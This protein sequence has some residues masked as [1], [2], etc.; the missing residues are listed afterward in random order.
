MKNLDLQKYQFI[1]F[2]D[3]LSGSERYSVEVWDQEK[4][5]I[6][7]VTN[8]IYAQYLDLGLENDE[9]IS[10]INI[11]T[12][13]GE[14]LDNGNQFYSKLLSYGT[15]HY[16]LFILS[17]I[18]L[19]CKT[20]YFTIKTNKRT[21][22]SN[23]FNL[24]ND[25]YNISRTTLLTYYHSENFYN[26]KYADSGFLPQQIRLPFYYSHKYDEVEAEKY[27]DSYRLE[28]TYRSGKIKRTFFESWNVMLNDY[29]YDALS[30]ALDSDFIYFDETYFNVK[31]FERE[32][33]QENK[34][35]TI[36]KIDGQ[37]VAK[38]KFDDSVFSNIIV[39]KTSDH[40]YDFDY[41][42]DS[43][44]GALNYFQ[45]ANTFNN[46]EDFFGP[47]YNCNLFM[48]IEKVPDN[49]Y[50]M[51]Q[52]KDIVVTVGMKISYCDKDDLVYM[53]K[54]KNNE[55]STS[56]NYL[57][58]FK[59]KIINSL[60]FEGFTVM[61]STL[62]MYDLDSISN[63]IDPI[64]TGIAFMSSSSVKY[65]W[66]INSIAN[67]EQVLFMY[68]LDGIHF[69]QLLIVNTGS[70]TT[71]E[72]IIDLPAFVID[73]QTVYFKI[74]TNS[75]FCGQ[76]SSLI[77]DETYV[78]TPGGIL[79]Q[80]L[81]INYNPTTGYTDYT[82][83]VSGG[84]FQGYVKKTAVSSFNSMNRQLNS[85]QFGNTNIPSTNY[86]STVPTT[87]FE[88]IYNESIH[89]SCQYAPFSTDPGENPG[90]PDPIA[91]IEGSIEILDS[92]LNPLPNPI[93][94]SASYSTT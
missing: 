80:L 49:G 7:L 59:Y 75:N 21:F 50:L 5:F 8:E 90:E 83:K 64:L 54:G 47:I 70:L 19:N 13:S 40:T 89:V 48:K 9:I 43:N 31:P 11:T 33:D 35:F 79:V 53:P 24:I 68:S 12:L 2:D 23:L 61:T 73:G 67:S 71:N 34:G 10:E 56:G 36:S 60:G 58:N 38:R 92:N 82:L 94:I 85:T 44:S 45:V 39:I 25:E 87:L 93:I 27:T 42:S 41:H 62:K 66:D 3:H 29:N 72:L 65:T 16:F 30:V 6:S 78:S 22:F 15:I 17:S 74:L 18:P 76:R 32:P 28:N 84:D 57:D 37:R 14:K 69:D 88:G 81:N 86:S 26:A 63:C 91:T 55:L 46:Y 77:V 4:I 1:R 52:M 20:F 51:L